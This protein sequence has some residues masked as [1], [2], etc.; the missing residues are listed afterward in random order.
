MCPTMKQVPAFAAAAMIR[1]QS[2]ML[3]AIGFSRNTCL[4]AARASTV[5]ATCS[6]MWVT[7]LTMS[8][9]LSASSSW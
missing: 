5:G 1:S 9:L 4:P 3:S 6:L 8:M 2:S 7:T